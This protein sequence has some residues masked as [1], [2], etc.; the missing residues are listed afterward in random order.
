MYFYMFILFTNYYKFFLLEIFYMKL[1]N[2]DIVYLK[3]SV[4]EVQIFPFIN[5]KKFFSPIVFIKPYL[6][7]VKFLAIVK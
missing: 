4:E 5:F 7:T 3:L 2:N 1:V 6:I